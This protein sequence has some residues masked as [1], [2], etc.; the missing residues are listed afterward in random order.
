MTKGGARVPSD[1]YVVGKGMGLDRHYELLALIQAHG[2]TTAIEAITILNKK[3]AWWDDPN[4][5]GPTET[6][7][8]YLKELWRLGLLDRVSKSTGNIISITPQTWQ[9]GDHPPTYQLS[10]LGKYVLS[11]PKDR[12][13]YYVSW[14]IINA[15]K[16]KIYPQVDKLF[17]LASLEGHI[18][19][20]DD[21][22]VK[23]TKKHGIYVEK[24][25]GKAIKFGWL[26]PTGIIYRS[27]K[28]YFNLNTKF[29]AY[30]SSIKIEQLF[31]DIKISGDS[32]NEIKVLINPENLLLTSFSRGTKYPFQIEISNLSNKIKKIKITPILLGL[33]NEIAEI[34]IEKE[35]VLG[36]KETKALSCELKSCAIELSDSLMPLKIGVIRIRDDKN[37]FSAFLPSIGIMNEDH[38]WELE[39]CELFRKLGLQVFHLTG[40]SDR[41]DAVIDLSGLTAQPEDLLAYLRDKSKEKILMET[42]IGEYGTGKLINDTTA[43]NTRGLNKYETHTNFVLKIEAIGQ[44][45]AADTFASGIDNQFEIVKKQSKHL[46]TLIDKNTL[47]YLIEKYNNDRNQQKVVRILKSGLRIK[48]ETIDKIFD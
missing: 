37:E 43:E 11:Q 33:F 27:S 39:L 42:T 3:F 46:I 20:N 41:P 36:A 31:H 15:Y 29:I 2:K 35:L 45:I 8:S 28:N 7:R 34:N 40:K 38:I 26:E 9:G 22:H 4:D 12:F 17:R 21:E 25:A 44:I 13:P 32:T 23:L 10:Q 48:K 14:C 47:K 1:L 18:P 19:I 5:E 30:L 16:N 6:C 24:H